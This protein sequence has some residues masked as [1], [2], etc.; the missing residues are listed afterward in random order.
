MHYIWVEFVGLNLQQ[1]SSVKV[2]LMGG[3][4]FETYHVGHRFITS[5]ECPT[6]SLENLTKNTYTQNPTLIPPLFP[7]SGSAPNLLSPLLLM[8]PRIGDV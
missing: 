4:Y 5:L 2:R 3:P 7:N 8:C 1:I 6:E